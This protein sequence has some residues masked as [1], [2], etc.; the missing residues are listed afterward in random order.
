MPNVV[1]LGLVGKLR[2]ELIES[3]YDIVAESKLTVDKKSR[4]IQKGESS[5]T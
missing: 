3:G 1:K 4:E 2:Q 5:G